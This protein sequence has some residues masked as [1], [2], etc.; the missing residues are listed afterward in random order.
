MKCE[1]EGY[2][3]VSTNSLWCKDDKIYY[4]ILCQKGFLC[5]K[6]ERNGMRR[7]RESM[8]KEQTTPQD[9]S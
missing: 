4:C 3:E 2:R 5:L 9:A 1:H 8:R 6:T 7:L